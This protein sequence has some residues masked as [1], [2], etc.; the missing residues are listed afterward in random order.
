MKELNILCT[1]HL[2]QQ[3]GSHFIFDEFSKILY[4][5]IGDQLNKYRYS[6]KDIEL[7]KQQKIDVG[8]ILSI[9]F[10]IEIESI[11]IVCKEGSI[12][13]I[14]D[15]EVENLGQFDCGI[16][17]AT[18]SKAQDFLIVVCGDGK[19]VQFDQE[20]LPS[21]EVVIDRFVDGPASI[22]FNIDG[23]FFSL[24]YEALNG[25]IVQTY[26]SQLEIFQSQS[27][28]DPEGGLVQTMF[29]K[30]KQIKNIVAWQPNCGYIAGVENQ[31]I[32]FWEKNGLRH[33]EF[34][35]QE[36]DEVLQVRWSP[37]GSILAVQYQHKVSLY[38]RQ[39]YKWYHKRSIC[40]KDI[41]GFQF[42][43][44]FEQTTLAIFTN[45]SL[46][47]Y[48]INTIYLQG[49][50]MSRD[51]GA[52][53]LT[54]FNKAVIPPP[55]FH[56][57]LQL[58]V[59]PV[60]LVYYNKQIFVL[61]NQ[62][63][64]I[65]EYDQ[66]SKQVDLP[67]EERF[68]HKLLYI[69]YYKVDDIY[70][71]SIILVAH[72]EGT[73]LIIEILLD[74]E[75]NIIQIWKRNFSQ[76]TQ[77]TAICQSNNTIILHSR[78][79]ER[80][81]YYPFSQK[82]DPIEEFEQLKA[83]NS[84]DIQIEQKDQF[85]ITLKN[86]NKLAINGQVISTDCTSFYTF[87]HFVGFTA[88]TP[89]LYH[90]LYVIDLTKQIIIDKKA[91]NAS[92]IERGS[93]I[94]Q[95]V[96]NDKLILQAP[97]GNFETIAPR[98]MVLYLA[99]DLFNQ[100]KYKLCYE[101]LRRHKLDMN[102]LF[103]LNPTQFLQDTDLIVQELNQS[104]LQIFIQAINNLVSFEL[105]YVVQQDEFKQISALIQEKTLGTTKIHLICGALI[106]SMNEESHLLTIITAMIRRDEIEEALIKVMKLKTLEQEQEEDLPP[107]LNPDNGKPYK[108]QHKHV[109]SD[110]ALEFICWLADANK[111]Y[112]VAL[113]TY[114]F[115][116]VKQVAQYTQKD[117]KEYL[118]QIEK[119]Q[120]IGDHIN[121]KAAVQLELKSYD[122]AISVLCS[123][124]E[125]QI[126]RAVELMTKYQRFRVGLESLKNTK[127]IVNV[128]EALGEYLMGQK[129]LNQAS[130]AFESG[131]LFD[132]A[133]QASIE[134]Y[135]TKRVLSF[136]PSE[137]QLIK[138][139]DSLK[140]ASRWAD[141][142][143]VYQFLNKLD[144]AI[145]YFCKAEE[146]KKVAK[147]TRG[148]Q[149]D[150]GQQLQL[151]FSIKSNKM[152]SAS[153]LFIQKY[154]RL[155]AVQEIKKEI[156]VLAPQ[157][158]QADFDAMSDVS[159][160]SS[161]SKT[162]YTMSITTGVRKKKQKNDKSFLSRN[163]KEGSPV[164]EEYLIEFLKDIQTQ[165]VQIIQSVK[166]FQNYLIYFNQPQLSHELSIKAKD[167][168]KIINKPIK[169][170]AA[171]VFEEQNPQ[172]LQLYRTE[173]ISFEFSQQLDNL[174][175]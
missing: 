136:N 15:D 27:K 126:L 129:Q 100:K 137:E 25:R 37:D 22:S 114:D 83:D 135:D 19:L 97:R 140:E 40:A 118:P 17:A 42:L 112:E 139:I 36:G 11:I 52:I 51:Y 143:R 9:D 94:V 59:S 60:D 55:M 131:G 168:L 107:H 147:C 54:D 31:Q 113:G 171:Q 146:W 34:N 96:S 26:D 128:K 172:V 69:P 148:K 158:L 159:Q 111:M 50:G 87:K 38:I 105:P 109:K 80:F 58:E 106:K 81:V 174:I 144:D 102:L 138:Y 165:S 53:Y 169:S 125:D 153:Q 151:T 160:K 155:R 119:F 2:A 71:G 16:Q 121:M 33:L 175:K 13:K 99:K 28:S 44:R 124:N 5:I 73:D 78:F 93:R 95:I 77:I 21:K 170:I 163:I 117:P 66:I 48:W 29:E 6:N 68:I 156:G 84:Y 173:Q 103:D 88:N 3:M 41:L 4:V 75:F 108:K 127:Y 61:I 18:W 64:L 150:L 67:E 74:K 116:L 122:K 79:G 24:N 101:M 43:E 39:N 56:K 130:L 86:N 85:F 132:K 12:I 72:E 154:E 82:D 115:Q 141:C 70:Q 142:G 20:I 98:V 133:L 145:H 49:L 164:E 89:D 10:I 1:Q 23:K 8:T 120:S 166:Q 30:P 167:Y 63:I 46:Q 57:K 32:I 90:L 123:G 157:Q 161:A 14:K 149:I 76:K 162:S 134:A 110:Q 104:F 91:L 45:N 152:L 7:L 62:K 65:C 35:L 47:F 92:N